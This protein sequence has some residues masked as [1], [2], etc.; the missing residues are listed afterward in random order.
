VAR[1]ARRS[2]SGPREGGVSYQRL[3]STGRTID[4][5]AVALGKSKGNGCQR[6]SLTR[7]VPKVQAEEDVRAIVLAAS[8]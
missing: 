5:I 3:V 2:E 7:L 6:I 8:D 1:C 4:D